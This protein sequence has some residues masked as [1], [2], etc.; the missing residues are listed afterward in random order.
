VDEEISLVGR[1]TQGVRVNRLE[2]ED[3]VAS[4]ALVQQGEERGEAKAGA[5]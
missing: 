3:S 4:I 1:D 2:P 5:E